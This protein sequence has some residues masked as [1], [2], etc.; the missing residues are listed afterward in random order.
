M[1]DNIFIIIIYYETLRMMRNVKIHKILKYLLYKKKK[2]LSC[3][4]AFWYI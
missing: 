2:M 1:K 4:N 3:A